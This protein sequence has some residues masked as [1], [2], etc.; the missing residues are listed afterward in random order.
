MLPLYTLLIVGL[1]W[2]FVTSFMA[3]YLHRHSIGTA[4]FFTSCTIAVFCSRSV[5]LA[6]PSR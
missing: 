5:V 2:G 3:L 4:Y 6:E 1:V